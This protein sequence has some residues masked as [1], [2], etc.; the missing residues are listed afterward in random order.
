MNSITWIIR[1]IFTA[2]A[3]GFQVEGNEVRVALNVG[4]AV[5]PND[6]QAPEELEKNAAAA[7]DEALS[8]PFINAAVGLTVFGALLAVAAAAK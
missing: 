5:G 2:F 8:V 4:I 6:G 3:E 7:G 1:R